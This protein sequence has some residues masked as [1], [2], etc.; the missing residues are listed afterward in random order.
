M[1][2]ARFPGWT[3]F[4]GI[5]NFV[6]WWHSLVN[7]WLLRV[8]LEVLLKLHRKTFIQTKKWT[9]SFSLRTFYIPCVANCCD[10]I[11]FLVKFEKNI[12]N[13]IVNTI[14]NKSQACFPNH[15]WAFG[16]VVHEFLNRLTEKL[17]NTY[18]QDRM[19][20]GYWISS[21]LDLR[22]KGKPNKK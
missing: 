21:E 3:V 16:V 6:T 4:N 15:F 1:R 7:T 10:K 14:K 19:A 11:L 2:G 18:I 9:I 5:F 8:F 13:I 17:I 20:W 12:F 22:P